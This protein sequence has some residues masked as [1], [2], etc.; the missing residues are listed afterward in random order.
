[1]GKLITP[2][3]YESAIDGLND[4]RPLALADEARQELSLPIL[5]QAPVDKVSPASGKFLQSDNQGAG[6]I[7]DFVECKNQV[8]QSI[9][10][11]NTGSLGN[12]NF[13]RM[14]EFFTAHVVTHSQGSGVS[15]W[16]INYTRYWGFFNIPTVFYSIYHRP[17]LFFA[18]FGTTPWSMDLE[19]SG[20]Y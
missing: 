10:L 2:L 5:N 4:V 3:H 6:L 17:W 13:G 12:I 11:S 7:R 14:I 16:D 8:T 15:F 20:F 19:V 1:M 9:S 18:G